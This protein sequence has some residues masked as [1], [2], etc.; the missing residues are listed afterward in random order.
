MHW[1]EAYDPCDGFAL[2]ATFAS[3]DDM[4]DVLLPVAPAVGVRCAGSRGAPAA[5]MPIAWTA[6]GL[7]AF[8]EGVPLLVT[9]DLSH[10][11]A[12]SSFL[13][14]PSQPGAPLS[15][16]GKT[17][18]LPTRLGLLEKSSDRTRLLRAAALDGTYAEQRDCTVSND[19][20]HVAC[21]RAGKAWVGAWSF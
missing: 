4:R 20:T 17:L 7:E 9:P 13:D 1:I 16:D 18:V 6:A 11:S 14:Q 19:G 10:A 12:L 15:P 8:V 2:H 3:G 5:T 21:V